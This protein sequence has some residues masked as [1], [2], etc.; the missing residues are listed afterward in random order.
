MALLLFPYS[1]PPAL[2]VDK[3]DCQDNAEDEEDPT[4]DGAHESDG[5]DHR[6]GVHLDR[7]TSI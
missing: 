1:Q 6:K 5:L 3:E 4:E 2:E 7:V